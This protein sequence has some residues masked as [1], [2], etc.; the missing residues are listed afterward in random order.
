MIILPFTSLSGLLLIELLIFMQTQFTDYL[1]FITN[2]TTTVVKTS[3]VNISTELRVN[4][5]YKI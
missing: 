4:F 2:K 3:G 5:R 1:N